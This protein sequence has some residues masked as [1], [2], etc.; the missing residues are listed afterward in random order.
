MTRTVDVVAPTRRALVRTAGGPHAQIV[1]T[2]LRRFSLVVQ[3]HIV[4]AHHRLLHNLLF[5]QD[6]KLNADDIR[7]TRARG[8]VSTIHEYSEHFRNS[9]NFHFICVSLAYL[10]V[11][12]TRFDFP[13]HVS[14]GRIRVVVMIDPRGPRVSHHLLG[15]TPSHATNANRRGKD[16]ANTPTTILCH[17]LHKIVS[18][19]VW[20]PPIYRCRTIDSFKG[21]LNQLF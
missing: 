12:Y 8:R 2:V 7:G 19:S 20:A 11:T 18:N 1:Q 3:I 14:V 6:A 5:A 17:G 9:L 10:F 15:T 21:F 16:V 13:I 4:H